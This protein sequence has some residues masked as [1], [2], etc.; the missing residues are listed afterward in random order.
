MC[1]EETHRS[2]RWFALAVRPRFDK[3]VARA[4][5][6]KGHETFLP[7]YRTHDQT[8]ARSHEPEL[9]LFPG[10][11]CCRF[12]VQNRL[13]ILTTPGVIDILGAGNAPVALD[14]IELASLR[15]AMRSACRIQP[16][17]FVQAGQRVRIQCGTLAGVEG[18]V[19]S[20]SQTLRLVLSISL[21]Q[22]SV[23]LEIGRDAVIAPACG[24]SALFELVKGD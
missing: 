9:P 24:E 5:E 6:R 23:L 11:V 1:L 17:P 15:T 4:L 16:F 2:S 21:L 8:G 10:Y 14:D 7:L 20:F 22:R 19:M 18:I 3:A 12:D 13:P